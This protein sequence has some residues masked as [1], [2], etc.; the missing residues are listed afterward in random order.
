VSGMSLT[1]KALAK[2]DDEKLEQLTLRAT[3]LSTLMGK[4]NEALEREQT[5]SPAPPPPP[6][7]PARRDKLSQSLP[8]DA[9]R[10]G[11]S[12]SL[13]THPAA[14]KVL[15]DKYAEIA[16]FDADQ[17]QQEILRSGALEMQK[18]TA[19]KKVLDEQVRVKQAIVL[20]ERAQDREWLHR[21]QARVLIWNEEEKKKIAEERSKYAE[22][23]L[24][25]E[26]QL[27]EAAA[28]RKRDDDEML[29]YEV[30]IL[31]DIHTE[32]QREK[33]VEAA[34]K[35]RDAKAL[36]DLALQNIENIKLMKIKKAEE[37]RAMRALEAQWSGV[38]DKQ[39]RQRTRQLALTYS[40]Q[41][42]QYAA[43]ESMQAIMNK[44]GQADE[45]R[46]LARQLADERA[47]KEKVAAQKAHRA[48]LQHDC[49]DVLAI[50]VRDKQVRAHA[51]VK[52]DSAVIEREKIDLIKAEIADSK[53]RETKRLESIA[54]AHE[55]QEQRRIQETRKTLEPF[56]MSRPERQMNAEMIGRLPSF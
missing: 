26:Q 53:F 11:F 35:A 37:F 32:L 21:E 6:P 27:R 55:L 46:A 36:K 34:K 4:V 3:E 15:V 22:I 10:P 5:L 41:A 9:D 1:A 14:K 42:K 49:L 24:Q 28:L 17:N 29:Q 16:L 48:Q 19:M 23:R 8:M 2:L 31:R 38:L 25:R 20:K 40:R 56:L 51:D 52:R 13:P 50:Q 54:Y 30:G 39:E 45:E 33:A 7:P 12:Q 47:A 43:S 44:Q 18:K